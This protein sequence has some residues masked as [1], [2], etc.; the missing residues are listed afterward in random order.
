MELDK[1]KCYCNLCFKNETITELESKNDK[2]FDTPSC[3]H[4]GRYF[5]YLKWCEKCQDFTSHRG[6]NKNALCYRCIMVKNCRKAINKGIHSSQNPETSLSNK[7]IHQKT[8]N[9]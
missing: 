9:S 4:N 7:E 6:F 5:S 2:E 8:I 3:N 1:N